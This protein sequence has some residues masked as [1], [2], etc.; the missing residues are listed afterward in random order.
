MR[1]VGR[2]ILNNSIYRESFPSILEYINGTIEFS[3]VHEVRV[4]VKEA[5]NIKLDRIIDI[6][7]D[8]I[9]EGLIRIVEKR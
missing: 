1:R 7:G 2:E 4:S 9:Q 6:I 5:V 8:G 3:I